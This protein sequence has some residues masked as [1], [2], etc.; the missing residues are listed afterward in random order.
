MDMNAVKERIEFLQ[1][2]ANKFATRICEYVSQFY[3]QQAELYLTDKTRAS[4]RGVLKLQG[5]EMLESKLFKFKKLLAWLKD[6]DTRNHYELQ[7]AYVKEVSKIYVQE[8]GDFLD[9]LAR[10][11]MQRKIN[12][13]DLDFLFGSHGNNSAATVLKT[14]IN[15]T[16][17]AAGIKHKLD[18]R[19]KKEGRRSGGNILKEDDE[20]EEE[21]RDSIASVD[22]GDQKMHQD[23]ALGHALLKITNLLVR[24]QNFLID[25]FGLVKATVPVVQSSVT[26]SAPNLDEDDSSPEGIANWQSM[27]SQPRQPFKDPKAEKRIQYFAIIR[28]LLESLFENVRDNLLGVMDAGLKY[29]QSYAV[30]MMVRIESHMREYQKTCHIFIVNLLD[31]LLRKASLVLE[32]FVTEQIKAIDDARIMAKKRTGIL[33]FFKVF[34]V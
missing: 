20:D 27:L 29:D 9:I 26:G 23:E 17:K 21:G 14:A 1:G 28:E 8:I 2:H 12:P 5:H 30:G 10:L 3:A 13:E 32:K 11:H 7:I 16:D 31:A 33:T 34:P 15:V 25:F 24:E 6:V 22:Q 19:K 4:Q 18:W